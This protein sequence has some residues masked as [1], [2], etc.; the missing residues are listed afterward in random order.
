MFDCDDEIIVT[1][2]NK[3][4]ITA[5]N[6]CALYC[7]RSFVFGLFCWRGMWSVPDLVSSKDIA[8]YTDGGNITSSATISTYWPTTPPAKPSN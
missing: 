3:T 4:V 1:D 7:S 8:C 5:D 2:D 6:V